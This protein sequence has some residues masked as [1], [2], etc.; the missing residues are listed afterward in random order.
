[1]VSC[2]HAVCRACGCVCV[3]LCVCI[4]K[5][6]ITYTAMTFCNNHNTFI[7]SSART[8]T[9]TYTHIHIHSKQTHIRRHTHTHTH[10]HIHSKQ[11]CSNPHRYVCATPT[12]QVYKKR[13]YFM[14]AGLIIAVNEKDEVWAG[15]GPDL[16]SGINQSHKAER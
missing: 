11:T 15:H 8:R 16:G 5:T 6:Y 12:P 7:P 4:N 14:T 10:I 9:H 13:C 2:C 3:W 1:C